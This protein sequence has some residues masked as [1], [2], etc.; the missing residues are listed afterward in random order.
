AM[1]AVLDGGGDRLALSP[2]APPAVPSDIDT[3]KA[4][5]ELQ[6]AMTTHAGVLRSATSLATAAAAVDHANHVSADA[7]QPAQHELRNLVTVGRAL[8]ASATAR[9][10]SRGAHSRTDYP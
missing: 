2:F 7:R 6:R 5:D 9:R 4:R 3:T 8:L 10:E 1:R